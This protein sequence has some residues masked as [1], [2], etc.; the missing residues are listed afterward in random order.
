MNVAASKKHPTLSPI[1]DV[2][3]RADTRRIPIKQG[4]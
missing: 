3:G 2:Q 1:E 4:R